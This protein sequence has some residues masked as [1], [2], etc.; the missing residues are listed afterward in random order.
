MELKQYQERTLEALA[1]YTQALRDE[2]VKMNEKEKALKAKD[3]SLSRDDRNIAEKA[4]GKISEKKYIKRTSAADESIPHVCLKVPTGGGKTLLGVTSLEHL[5]E[6]KNGLIFWVIP[7]SAIYKQT[8][9]AFRTRAHPYRRRLEHISQG[10]IKLFEKGDRL[11]QRDIDNHL[12]LV[13][14]MFQSTNRK[15]SDRT[16]NFP[17]DNS[18]YSSFFPDQLNTLKN[19]DLQQRYPDLEKNEDGT[20]V[21]RS[22][23]NVLKMLR[24]VVV[25]DEA[26]KTYGKEEQSQEFVRSINRLNPRFVLELSAT[27]RNNISNILV[28]VSGRELDQEEMIKM[29]LQIHNLKDLDWQATLDKAN[30]KQKYLE[31]KAQ[32][33]HSENQRYIRPIALVRV[34]R[35]GE[36]QRGKGYIHAEDV[37]EYLV[38][39]LKVQPNAIRIQATGRDELKG[40]TL[41]HPCNQVRWIITKDAL[42]E[43][44]DCAFAYILV[45]L[46][47]TKAPTALT[48][49]VG[50]VMR[51]PFA[52]KIKNYPDLNRCYIFYNL[53][54]V[55]ETLAAIRLALEAEGL[56]DLQNALSISDEENLELSEDK[57][58][59]TIVRRREQYKGLDFFLPKVLHKNLDKKNGKKPKWRLLNYERDILASVP[60]DELLIDETL[61]LNKAED[62]LE[63]IREMDFDGH[64]TKL[65]KNP[66][67]HFQPLLLRDFAYS[68]AGI[69]PNPWQAARIAQNFLDRHR[70]KG[71]DEPTLDVNLNFLKDE[72]KRLLLECLDEKAEALFKLKVDENTIS[73]HLETDDTLNYEIEKSF[74]FYLAPEE[75]KR[76]V[77]KNNEPLQKNF[78]E[79]ILKHHF[80]GLE[81][82]FA[83]YLDSRKV[84]QWWHRVAVKQGYRLQGW[85]KNFVYPDFV[86]VREDDRI[87]V[88][89]TKGDQFKGNDDTNY[90]EDLLNILENASKHI[91]EGG[92]IETPSV[93]LRILFQSSWKNDANRALAS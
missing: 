36:K 72:L 58:Q 79:P 31:Q 17:K 54:E 21:R 43:G 74:K 56:G 82:S 30:R 2:K 57:R 44:W 13:L 70:E 87:F 25:L 92:K 37:Q 15:Q 3:L 48:Q 93:T 4:W 59:K 8:V 84:L 69:V 20:S 42:K 16:I 32:E 28:D 80:N 5:I 63:D 29:P 81:E 12:C 23:L 61:H 85:Q 27:P 91:V 90:K 52:Q 45:L 19:R 26:H 89:E 9:R 24:P 65:V 53:F 76:L 62:S 38:A 88:F 33:L 60:W 22:F 40:D 71:Y 14:Y 51:Q 41:T 78:L 66:L 18:L 64:D 50:R 86:A 10:K 83:L 39:H 68:L 77:H 1:R 55:G 11:T 75:E 6:K 49:M 67:I 35:T 7:T 73:F 34:E 46:D 47:N